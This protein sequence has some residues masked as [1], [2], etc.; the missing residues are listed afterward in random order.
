LVRLAT[1]SETH[2]EHNLLL[3]VFVV[4]LTDADSGSGFAVKEADQ[5]AASLLQ[6]VGVKRQG[7]G[8]GDGCNTILA[9]VDTGS[10]MAVKEIG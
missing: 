3:T 2:R 7:T 5:N 1:V 8:V 6:S 9:D 10:G 4:T